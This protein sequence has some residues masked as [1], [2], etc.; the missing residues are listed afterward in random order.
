MGKTKLNAGRKKV[1][2]GRHH[3]ATTGNRQARTLLV[4]Q[5]HMAIHRLIEMGEIKIYELSRN[6][7]KILVKQYCK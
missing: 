5:S 3:V 6:M 1:E 2:S 4:S 7:F